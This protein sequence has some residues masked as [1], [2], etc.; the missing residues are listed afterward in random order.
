MVREIQ[1]A[2]EQAV[3]H[4][5]PKSTVYRMLACQGWWKITTRP[6]HPRSDT[7]AQEA[8]KKNS[9]ARSPKPSAGQR[10]R[11]AS[12]AWMFPD[13]GRL[14]RLSDPRPGWSPPRSHPPPR[15]EGAL[16]SPP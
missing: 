9:P 14:G 2:H 5:V 13:E 8:W 3:G 6:R 7:Q 16:T 12:C 15:V 1:A 10:K 11:G 4:P